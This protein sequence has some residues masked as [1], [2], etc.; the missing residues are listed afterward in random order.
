MEDNPVVSALKNL[1]FQSRT[2]DWNESGL[3]V[4]HLQ[5]IQNIP[6]FL[7]IQTYITFHFYFLIGFII[8]S[9]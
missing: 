3:E 1:S 2:R 8:T 6:W 9:F 5:M 4:F 7:I